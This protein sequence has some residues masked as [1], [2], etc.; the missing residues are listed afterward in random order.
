MK[1]WI[2]DEKLEHR[3]SSV[4]P[5]LGGRAPVRPPFA[6]RFDYTDKHPSVLLLLHGLTTRTSTRPSSFCY[7]V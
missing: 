7:T 6:T 3:I 4:S 1:N 5:G 2:A